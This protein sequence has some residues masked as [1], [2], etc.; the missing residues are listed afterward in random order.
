MDLKPTMLRPC[1]DM[2]KYSTSRHSL[3]LYNGVS[4]AGRY[5]VPP[6]TDINSLKAIL[7]HAVAQVVLEQPMMRIGIV[8]EDKQNPSFVHVPSIN[9]AEHTQWFGASSPEEV[10][11]NLCKHFSFQHGQSWSDIEHRPPWKIAVLPIQ[12][13]QKTPAEVEIV[14]S[15]HHAINDGVSG[16]IFHSRLLETLKSPIKHLAGFDG[17]KLEVSEPPTLPPPQNELVNSRISWP[18]FLAT[19]W[20]AFGPSWLKNKPAVLPWKARPYG[21]SLSNNTS[22]Y[23]IRIPTPVAKKL[24][25]AARAHSLTLSPLLHA[26]IVA[27][28]SRRLSATEAPAFE[29]CTPISLRR[30]VPAAAAFDT[31][32]QMLVLVS[33]AD[34]PV[35]S[36]LVTKL[37]DSSGPDR[38]SAVWEVAASVKAS[39][40]DK[41]A[42]LPNDD[43]GAML[44]YVS[45]FHDFFRKKDGGERGSS[46]EISNVGALNGGSDDDS[47]RLTRAMFSQSASIFGPGFSANIAG[48]AGGEI[49]ITLCWNVSV[50]DNALME[51]LAKDLEVLIP[52]V[53]N[54]SPL[55]L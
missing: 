28:L 24:L 30:Y 31:K 4:I 43:Q 45:D 11:A 36:S 27:S 51:G 16:S 55:S 40:N 38:E 39:M 18:F 21:I 1:G 50:V 17:K 12:G 10:D 9:I 2:E 54:G 35:S 49:T 32:K 15:F 33:T 37:R 6:G 13:S 25:A 23:L 7:Q 48:I 41:L 42:S 34:H 20:D 19:L 47:W 46:W 5:A 14:Y 44:K 52:E 3:G 26:L 22:T 53:A 8:D 29:P